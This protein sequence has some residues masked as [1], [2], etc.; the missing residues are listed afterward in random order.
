MLYRHTSRIAWY[1]FIPVAAALDRQIML[2]LHRAEPEG[3]ICQDI[4]DKIGRIHQSV[5]GNLRHLVERGFVVATNEYGVTRSNRRA[6]K[7]RIAPRACW[8]E[9]R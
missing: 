7:W 3:L 4:E 6:I 8:H 9:S 2:A 1:E 5:S